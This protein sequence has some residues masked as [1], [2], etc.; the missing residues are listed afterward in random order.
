MLVRLTYFPAF[1]GVKNDKISVG[2]F[3]QT[4]LARENS[5][6][7]RRIF[8]QHA[9]D[10]AGAYASAVY[11][12]LPDNRKHGLSPRSAVGGFEKIIVWFFVL[13][14]VVAAEGIEKPLA[15]A[16][17]ARVARNFPCFFDPVNSPSS[18]TGFPR[19]ITVFTRPR[20]SLPSKSV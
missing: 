4:S 18:I 14:R 16:R 3:F 15:Y 20:I 6:N 1:P 12:L 11:P 5:Q 19:E 13:G 17:A 7:A 2:A 9:R 8:R 10:V